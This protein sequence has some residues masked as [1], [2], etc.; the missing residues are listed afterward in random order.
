MILNEILTHF[1]Y[2]MYYQ[3][4]IELADNKILEAKRTTTSKVSKKGKI[5]RHEGRLVSSAAKKSNDPMYKRMKYH[6]DKY[7][8]LKEKLKKKYEARV[9]AKARR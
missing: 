2:F 7:M 1:A 4:L 9:R 3:T 6:K 5:K 8:E